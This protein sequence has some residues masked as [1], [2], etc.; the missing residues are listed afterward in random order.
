M[1]VIVIGSNEQFIKAD[2]SNFSDYK[3]LSVQTSF[4]EI[5]VSADQDHVYFFYADAIELLADSLREGKTVADS[6]NKC[7]ALLKNVVHFFK[8][9]RKNCS[10]VSL[11]ALQSF[12]VAERLAFIAKLNL[13]HVKGLKVF[14]ENSS[15]C[16]DVYNLAALQIIKDDKSLSK[17]LL[18]LEACSL[19]SSPY[20]SINIEKVV[21][22]VGQL[23][24]DLSVA[25]A[26]NKAQSKQNEQLEK[27]VKQSSEENEL[28]IQQLHHVQEELESSFIKVGQLNQAKTE[29]E[30]TLANAQKIEQELTSDLSVALAE[31]KAQSK[32]NEQLEKDVKQSSEENELLIQQLHH[33][34]EEL[35]SSFIKVGQLNQAKTELEV[36]LANAQK[37]EQELTSD[38][39]VAL[40]ENKAQSKQNEQLEKDVKQSSEENELLIQQLHYVQEELESLF[41]KKANHQKP[42]LNTQS[43]IVSSEMLDLQ[44]TLVWIKALYR[45]DLKEHYKQS[46]RFRTSVKKLVKL[47]NQSDLFDSEW[48]ANNYSDV[49]ASTMEPAMHYLLYGAFEGRNPS[50]SFNTLNYIYSYPDI[51]ESGMN[52]LVHY[53]KFGQFESREADPRRRCLPAPNGK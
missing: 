33:V 7:F 8:Q 39:S 45:K 44:A 40:A 22:E 10:L 21:K 9:N 47:L 37:I 36:T 19:L 15:S 1:A 5:A 3:A 41:N 27:D 30:V 49:K 23:K 34:Q 52:P 28:L 12:D 4:T 24:S 18:E 46:R 48:Y 14:L 38:L 43:N 6:T 2:I 53:L 16:I 17:T 20:R 13:S 29:L 31:N 42:S 32:Q 35:E 25:L 50:N 51:A 11:N 26:E